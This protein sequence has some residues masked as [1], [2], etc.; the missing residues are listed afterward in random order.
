MNGVKLAVTPPWSFGIPHVASVRA[1]YFIFSF[2]SLVASA[3]TAST[4]ESETQL[5]YFIIYNQVCLPLSQGKSYN[6]FHIDV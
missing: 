6:D 4:A 2:L 1:L 5:Q 3:L